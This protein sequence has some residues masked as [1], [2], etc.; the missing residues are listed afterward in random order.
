MYGILVTIL[1]CC[2][3]VV[4]IL[5]VFYTAMKLILFLHDFYLSSLDWKVLP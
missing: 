2:V 4:L 5:A 3:L 1:I